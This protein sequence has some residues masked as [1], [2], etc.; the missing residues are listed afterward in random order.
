MNK[1]HIESLLVIERPKNV[2]SVQDTDIKLDIELKKSCNITNVVY[3]RSVATGPVLKLPPNFLSEQ[4][5][6]RLVK[7]LLFRVN[8]RLP[9]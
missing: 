5:E 1:K 3:G 6:G 7:H 9:H 8:L 2:N 4:P